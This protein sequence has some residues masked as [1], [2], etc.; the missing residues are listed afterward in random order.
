MPSTAFCRSSANS[1]R[2]RVAERLKPIGP[3]GP[4]GFLVA[5]VNQ[6]GV[7]EVLDPV[8]AM[9]GGEGRCA[10]RDDA[11]LK[12]RAVFDAILLRIAVMDAEIAT[13]GR[14]RNVADDLRDADAGMDFPES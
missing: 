9:L 1:K 4:A 2:K 14:S 12:E 6:G 13:A 11:V 7:D 5:H 8:N 10:E 3:G